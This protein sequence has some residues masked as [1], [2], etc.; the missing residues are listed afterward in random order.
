M[1][2]WICPDIKK[3]VKYRTYRL[4]LFFLKSLFPNYELYA[5]VFQHS[6]YFF[7]SHSSFPV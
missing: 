6:F 1:P 5:Q 2:G 4:I 3:A 7:L